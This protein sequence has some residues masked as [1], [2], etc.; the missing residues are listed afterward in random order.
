MPSIK[1]GLWPYDST[2][3]LFPSQTSSSSVQS[4]PPPLSQVWDGCSSSHIAYSSASASA[5]ISW[6]VE[7]EAIVAALLGRLAEAAPNVHHTYG[8]KVRRG[9]GWLGRD[10]NGGK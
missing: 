6:L 5:P 8:A 7:N 4:P 9:F 3:L 1:H 10:L 2:P